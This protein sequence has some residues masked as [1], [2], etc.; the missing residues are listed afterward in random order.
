LHSDQVEDAATALLE[1]DN[2]VAGTLDTSWSTPGYPVE[3]TEIF[4]HGSGGILE[5]NDTR[6]RLY[7]NENNGGYGKGWMT[8]HRAEM[9]MADFDLSPQYGGEGYYNEDLDFIK[10]CQQKKTPRVSW[11]DGL[12]VQEMMDA[13]YRSATEGH[14]KL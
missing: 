13:L 2:D 7:L 6:L 11:F 5:I 14:V 3:Q 8:W 9:D 1:F 10:A 4:L 12:K